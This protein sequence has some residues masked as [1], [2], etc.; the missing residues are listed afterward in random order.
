[1]GLNRPELVFAR[2]RHLVLLRAVFVDMARKF[3]DVLKFLV[4]QRGDGWIDEAK[5]SIGV[6]S[7]FGGSDLSGLSEKRRELETKRMFQQVDSSLL[8]VPSFANVTLGPKDEPV[9]LTGWGFQKPTGR[10]F[11]NKAKV[12][13]PKNPQIENDPEKSSLQFLYYSVSPRAAF[14]GLAM[15]ALASWSLELAESILKGGTFATQLDRPLTTSVT[16]VRSTVDLRPP[17]IHPLVWNFYLR[18]MIALRALDRDWKTEHVVFTGGADKHSVCFVC[19]N[20]LQ[21][22]ITGDHDWLEQNRNK[23]ATEE[24]FKRFHLH[25]KDIDELERTF[26]LYKCDRSQWAEALKQ[27]SDNLDERPPEPDRL[28]NVCINRYNALMDKTAVRHTNPYAAE[29]KEIVGMGERLSKLYAEFKDDL[30]DEI[31]ALGIMEKNLKSFEPNPVHA[32][33]YADGYHAFRDLYSRIAYTG[34]TS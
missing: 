24:Y 30:P 18:D 11:S 7:Q 10:M 15:D 19:R 29:W 21:K 16:P 6:A 28:L 32:K 1:M 20:I 12:E 23:R 9:P 27:M 5:A 2:A 4:W 33:I 13:I 3:G 31:K 34:E 26:A 25:L 14:S 8:S 17:A 22:R